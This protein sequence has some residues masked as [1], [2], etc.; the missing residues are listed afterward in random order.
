MLMCMKELR[1]DIQLLKNSL[2][3]QQK[4]LLETL[5]DIQNMVK[6]YNPNDNRKR[7][8]DNLPGYNIRNRIKISEE[9]L[10]FA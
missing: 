10:N 9:I 4:H 1:D 3:E 2:I 5:D 6:K 7:I 8:Y